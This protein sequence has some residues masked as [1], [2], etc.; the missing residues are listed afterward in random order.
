MTLPKCHARFERIKKSGRI[1][2]VSVHMKTADLKN[3]KFLSSCFSRILT[4]RSFVTL[5]PEFDN[6]IMSCLFSNELHYC[7][8]WDKWITLAVLYGP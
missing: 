8:N 1:S 2:R 7:Y 5:R 3:C 6:E 4:S